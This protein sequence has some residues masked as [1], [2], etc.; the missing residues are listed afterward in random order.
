[1]TSEEYFKG[2]ELRNKENKRGIWAAF[3]ICEFNTESE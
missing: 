1:M 3:A 2:T